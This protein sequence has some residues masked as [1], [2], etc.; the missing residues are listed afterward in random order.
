MK[1]NFSNQADI[2]AR[3]RPTYPPK[4]FEFIVSKVKERKLAWDCATG[5][6]QSAK[7][8]SRHFESVLAT[9]ISGK[10]IENAHQ[11]PNV[12]YSVQPAEKT[13][14]P[15]HSVNLITVS[16]AVHWFDFVKF[17]DEVRRTAKPHGWIA[18]WMYALLRLSE[19]I[20]E[21]IDRY[22]YETLGNYWDKERKYV[23][24]NYVTIPFPFQEIDVPNF[25]IEYD[26][27]IAE[28]EG[29]LNT[30]SALQKFIAA[31]GVSPVP[32]LM[33]SLLPHWKA[34]KMKVVFPL[35]LRMG[36]IN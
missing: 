18:V 26:W 20:N 2:Y 14:I 36:R 4:L 33:K 8:L 12:I 34:E 21:L 5:N 29:Y 27:T 17:Y 32:D 9:D 23:D 6:G 11:A 16:Q 15:D 7:E 10:Q 22:H 13:D 30:W 25:S 24:N 31:N 35:Y 3:Y 1:D 28:L 19:P